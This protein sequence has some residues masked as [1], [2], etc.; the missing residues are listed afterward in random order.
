MV[1]V[2]GY[3]AQPVRASFKTWLALIDKAL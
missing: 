2:H 3:K 1:A